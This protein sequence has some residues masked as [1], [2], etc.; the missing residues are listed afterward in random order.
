M[1]QYFGWKQ[2]SKM[3]SVYIHLSGRD[4]DDAILNVHGIKREEQSDR[5]Q[6][7]EPVPCPR[8]KHRNESELEICANCGMPLTEKAA[9]DAEQRE[10]RFM[11]LM[12]PEVVERMVEKQVQRL[13][14]Q[15]TEKGQ[16]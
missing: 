13:L 1:C 8:C 9:T 12:D 11:D 2:V 6:E 4:I 10:Q 14:K 15:R 5:G 16:R 7:L 3:P